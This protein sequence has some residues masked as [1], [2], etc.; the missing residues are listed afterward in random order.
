MNANANRPYEIIVAEPIDPPFL[1][2]LEEIGS[3]RV[4][5]DSGPESL[6]SAVAGADA[7]LVRAKAHITA[8]IIEA[9]PKLKV[10]A[11]A[12]TTI[13]HIDLKAAQRR[14]IRIVYAPHVAVASTAEFTLAL[15]LALNRRLFHFD[16]QVRDGQFDALRKPSGGEM[17]RRTLGLLGVDPVGERLD[18]MCR[19]AFDMPVIYHDPIGAKLTDSPA[20]AVSLDELL[21]RCDVLSVHLSSAT[22]PKGLLSAERIARLKPTAIV[23]NT[24]RGNA[25]D[26]VALARALTRKHIAGAALDVFETEPLPADHPLRSAP[27][28][29]LT[30]RIAGVTLDASAERFSVADDVI[31]VLRGEAP[32][33]PY[34]IREAKL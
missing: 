8:R 6:L 19:A 22:D 17:G 1:A 9:A 25:I 33:H 13:D 20:S 31:R 7:L 30:P 29:I 12:S 32:K 27:N 10:I 3:V 14:N 11:R 15:I 18:R 5:S 16:R 26:T 4:L 23:V 21:A 2:K 24:S 28:C 34:E